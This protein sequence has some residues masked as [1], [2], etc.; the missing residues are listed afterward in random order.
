MKNT[1]FWIIAFIITISSAVYQ[2]MTGPTYPVRGEVVMGDDVIKYK[3][4]RTH[5][6]DDDHRVKIEVERDDINGSVVYRRFK[7][8]DE[9]Q[10]IAM[11]RDG[12]Y[13]YADLP[14]QPP[15]GKLEYKVTLVHENTEASLSGDESVVIRFKGGVPGAILIPHIFIMFAAMFVSNRAGIEALRPGSNPR[16]LALWATGLVLVGGLILGPLVQKY[17]FGALWTGFPFGHDLTDNKTLIAA[18]GWISAVIAGRG[19]KPAR[20]WVLGAAVLLLVI[21]LIPHSLMGSELD[22]SKME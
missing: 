17:A 2:R 3:L 20:W 15:A 13:L 22:Y 12:A 14:H 9:W 21:Y 1:L 11:Q 5:G 7:T 6:G 4:R 8:T 19:G 10:S 18:I 16:K